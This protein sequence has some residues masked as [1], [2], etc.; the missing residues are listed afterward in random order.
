[1]EKPVSINFISNA[2][3]LKQYQAALT[4]IEDNLAARLRSVAE[5]AILLQAHQK[6][7]TSLPTNEIKKDTRK[8]PGLPFM[9]NG[10]ILKQKH[11]MS[12]KI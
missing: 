6:A 12:S 2:V 1:V 7:A 11:L 10:K 3:L 4:Q 5:Q 8:L 9:E